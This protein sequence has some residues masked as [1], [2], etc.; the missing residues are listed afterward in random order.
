MSSGPLLEKIERI[1]RRA[2]R[3]ALH[4]PLRPNVPGYMSYEERLKKLNMLSL[5][6][7]RKVISV[8]FALRIWQSHFLTDVKV[9]L[10]CSH[11]DNTTDRRNANIFRN[12]RNHSTPN[13]PLRY[14][15][16]DVNDFS[17]LVNL[18]ERTDQNKKRI[19]DYLL[20]TSNH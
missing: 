17:V 10:N 11:F 12:I 16:S 15:M 9:K 20:D 2:T 19:T 18:N 4:C 14:L 6:N 13:S 7:R 5:A 3:F 8:C 1:Q